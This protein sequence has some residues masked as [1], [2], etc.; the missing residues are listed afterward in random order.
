[1]FTDALKSVSAAP[2]KLLDI[3]Q[4]AAASLEQV[5]KQLSTD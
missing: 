2:P 5:A 1:M 3:V 4:I